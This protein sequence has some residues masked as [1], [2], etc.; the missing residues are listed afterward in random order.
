MLPRF[1]SQNRPPAWRGS[2]QIR[3]RVPWRTG[4]RPAKP[5]DSGIPAGCAAVICCRNLKGISSETDH[6]RERRLSSHA[7]YE[8]NKEK[9]R[10]LKT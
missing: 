1:P 9:P 5:C 8:V 3:V 6:V 10:G 2:G 4:Y 7:L